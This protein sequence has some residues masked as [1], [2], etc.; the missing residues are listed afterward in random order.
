MTTPLWTWGSLIGV[1]GG[2][3]D[4]APTAAITSV[5]ID[6][7]TID[8]GDLFVALKDQRDGHDFVTAAFKAGAAAALVSEHYERQPSDGALLRV[9]EPLHALEDIGRVARFRGK[10]R[11]VAVTG[12]VGKTGTKEM[13]RACLATE[14]TVHASEKSYNNHWGVPLTLAKLPAAAQFGVFEIGMNHAGEITPLTRMVAP[15]IAV[16]TTVEPV[17]LGFFTNEDEI[18]DAK[19]EIFL[20][21]EPGGIAILN[22]DNRHFDRLKTK[23]Q[24]V[25]AK[26]I[27]FGASE[28]CDVRALEMTVTGEGTAVVLQL[29]GR[30]IRY[31]VGAPGRHIAM[32]SLAVAAVMECLGLDMSTAL[33]PLAG[34]TAPIGRGARQTLA[35]ADGRILLIDE[36]YNANPASMRAALATLGTVARRDFP[37]RIAVL[38]DMRELGEQGA[39]LHRDLKEP[40]QV[41]DIDLVLACGPLMRHLVDTLESD[42]VA[43]WAEKSVDLVASLKTALRPGDVVM[44]KGSLGTNMAPLIRAV[45]ELGTAA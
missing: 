12:S 14:G 30:S 33:Q 29:A 26:V 41:A 38:G 27:S 34:V 6:T 5:S 4:G 42:R 35:V 2:R 20:G 3:G 17:H 24:A 19:A 10:P 13:L 8:P 11:V 7:R 43:G 40:L 1:T 28:G 16:V 18:A 44:I 39:Q 9:D 21:L 36:S 25:G 37:R 15:Q 45:L 32:N 22:R 23:A 31:T